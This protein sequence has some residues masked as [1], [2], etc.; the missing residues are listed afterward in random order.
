[1]RAILL[2][3]LLACEPSETDKN[4]GDTLSR[5][6]S[7]TG[8]DSAGTDTHDTVETGHTGETAQ[9]GDS[10]T[11]GGGSDTGP[12]IEGPPQ[13]ILFIGDGMGHQHVAGGGLYQ[14]GAA[15]SLT[16]E[17]LPIQGRLRSASLSGITDSAASATAYSTGEKTWNHV[18]GQDRDGADLANILDLARERGMSVGVV[19]TDTL[20]GATPASFMAH[21][22]DRGMG[23]EIATQIAANLPDVIMGGGRGALEDMVIDLDI[24]LVTTSA[25]LMASTDDGS[26]LVGLFSNYELPYV[27]DGLGDAPE[28]RDMVSVA[29]SRLEGDPDGF[30]LMVEGA[31]I[32]HAS[33]AKDMDRVHLET[34]A[35]DKAIAVGMDWASRRAD[36]TLLVTADHECGGLQVADTGTAGTPPETTFRWGK[37][38]NGDPPI[39]GMGEAASVFDDARLDNRWVYQVLTAAIEQRAVEA[40]DDMAIVDGWMDDLPDAVATQT[41]DTSYESGY[42]QL[43]ALH[44]TADADG[45]R[46]GIDGA[47]ELNNNA[48]VVL[49]DIDYGEST[50]LGGDG[51]AF[52]DEFGTSDVLLST[53]D[54]DVDVTGLGFDLAVVSLGAQEIE[55]GDFH[56]DSGIR[57]LRE[58]WAYE[59]DLWWL[60]GVVNYDDGNVSLEDDPAPDAGLTGLTEGGFETWV[61]WDS[62]FPDGLEGLPFDIAVYAVLVNEDGSDISNQTLPALPDETAPGEDTLTISSVAVLSVDADGVAVGDAAIE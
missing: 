4:T 23:S 7:A 33:H 22:E 45:L 12:M 52:P 39:F 42:A 62:V 5:D 29:L 43:D 19:T 6:D 61:P 11:S 18:V 48:L 55:Y 9:T 8:D 13:V 54:L 36:A 14:N 53:L 37:H 25:E 21:V 44:V 51:T 34:D 46:I 16:M 38:T 35:F 60:Y 24:Q 15:G 17:T 40:P 58:P 27:Y 26:R 49:I 31:R 57:G 30:F 10:D 56:E 28:L 59:E 2:T 1:M 47:F 41:W 20:T 32:D 50:G 3:L